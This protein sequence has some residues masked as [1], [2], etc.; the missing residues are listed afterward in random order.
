M[1]YRLNKAQPHEIQMHSGLTPSFTGAS[2]AM[3]AAEVGIYHHPFPFLLVTALAE[4]LEWIHLCWQTSIII[5]LVCRW[6]AIKLPVEGLLSAYGAS[7]LGAMPGCLLWWK[8]PGG[9]KPGSPS[10]ILKELWSVI[11]LCVNSLLHNRGIW[12]YLS[13]CP[14]Q[15]KCG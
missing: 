10:A 2:G 1:H 3:P 6:A 8:R 5:S 4:A 12:R 15:P 7:P 13:I 11:T 9:D 14:S